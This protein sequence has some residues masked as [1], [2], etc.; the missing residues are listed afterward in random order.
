MEIRFLEAFLA[1]AEEGSVS[2]AASRLNL[3]QP[4]VSR[5]LKQMEAV[6]QVRLFTRSYEGMQLTERGHS[7]Y[8]D[9]R[10]VWNELGTLMHAH[11]PKPLIRLGVTPFLAPK[12]IPNTVEELRLK[13]KWNQTKLDCFDFIKLLEQGEIDAAIIEG[14]PEHPGFYSCLI[15]TESYQVAIPTDHPLADYDTVSLEQCLAYPQVLPPQKSRFY[16]NWM[17]LKQ[18][19][20]MVESNVT[21]VP[22]QSLLYSVK[23]QR[24]L[25]FFPELMIENQWEQDL[26]F[27]KI[28]RGDLSRKLY[29]HTTNEAY[30]KPVQQSLQAQMQNQQV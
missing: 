24:G 13:V 7:L 23:Q 26:L 22:Y 3:T 8:N 14:Y 16:K 4:A 1:V 29:L 20:S 28:A 11:M 19:L 10:P 17:A 9:I 27:K 5:Q 25:A 2:K 6:L 18:K 15:S 30:L 21:C 12:Y